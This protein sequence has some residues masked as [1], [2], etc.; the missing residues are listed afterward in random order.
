MNQAT[1]AYWYAHGYSAAFGNTPKDFAE[2]TSH[3]LPYRNFTSPHTGDAINPDDGSLDFDGDM[4]YS[5]E[6]GD[7]VI[8]VKT[9]KGDMT[10]P[11]SYE[12]TGSD[13]NVQ[14]NGLLQLR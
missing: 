8:T 10:I 3:G 12:A 1:V 4:T 13:I 6:G 5:V 7:P 14:F 9:S 11:G 2:M